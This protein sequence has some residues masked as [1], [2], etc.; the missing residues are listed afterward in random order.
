ML[1]GELYHGDCLEI[2]PRIPRESV[3]LVLCDLPYGTT[4]STWD[5][6]I[7]IDKLWAEYT[8]ILKPRG[9]VALFC[10]Q[11]FTSL[12]VTHGLKGKLHYRYMWVWLK[13]NKTNIA[14]AHQ[15]P[16]RRYEEIAVFGKMTGK[17]NPQNL[18]ELA[19]PIIRQ[20]KNGG[21]YRAGRRISIQKYTGYPANVIE[22]KTKSSSARYHPSEKP[23]ALLRYLIR[24]YTDAGDMVLDNTMGSGSTCV[25]AAIE[26][27]RYIGIERDDKYYD[28]ACARVAEAERQV[29]IDTEAT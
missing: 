16:L 21:I 24:T 8:R 28:I 22:F 18:I 1:G 14:H 29:R 27:R 4:A 15:Q 11:P 25:A 13:S 10:V 3:D 6:I 7:P 12:L 2:M 20:P 9:T 19:E 5:R 17:Y 26:G 23:E